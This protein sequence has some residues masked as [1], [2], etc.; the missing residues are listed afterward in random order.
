MDAKLEQIVSR[1]ALEGRVTDI[2]PLGNGLINDTFRVVTD[3]PDDFVLQRQNR[4]GL[5]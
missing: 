5:L 4:Q 1:F 2:R 3:G